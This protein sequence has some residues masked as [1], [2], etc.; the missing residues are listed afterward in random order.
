MALSVPNGIDVENIKASLSGGVLTM[1][2]PK[3]KTAID[4][5]VDEEK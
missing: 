4:I 1:T 2:F 5:E 3:V